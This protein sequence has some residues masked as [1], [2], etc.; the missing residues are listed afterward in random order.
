MK[1]EIGNVISITKSPNELWRELTQIFTIDNPKWLD[2]ERMGRWQGETRQWLKF[3]S[4][5][6][7]VILVPRGF[8]GLLLR[9]CRKMGIQYEVDDHR[10]VLPEVNFAFTGKLRSYQRQAVKDI[11]KR[12]FKVLQA[13]TGSGKTVMALSIIAKRRQPAL[14]IVHTKELLNQWLERIETF[15][16]IPKEQIGIIGNGKKK[17]GK[18]ITVGIIN[19]IYPIANE[20]KQYFGHVIVDECHR[21]P[22]KTFTNAVILFDSRYMLGLSATPY[23]QDGLTK[24]IG[25]FLGTQVSVDQSLLDSDD[26]IRNVEIVSRETKFVTRFNQSEEYPRMLRELTKDHDRNYMIVEDVAKEVKNPG[27]C[28]VLSDRKSH[29]KAL[30]NSLHD[31]G[32]EADVLTGDTNNHERKAIVER[33]NDGEIDVLIATAQLIGEGFDSKRLSTLFLTTPIKFDGRLI[34]YVGR[35]LRPAPG[36]DKAMVYDYV[37]V[38]VGVLKAAAKSRQRVYQEMNGG[39]NA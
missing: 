28:L 8:L 2:N 13:P 34:Q 29:C 9:L 11:G 18:E 22:S 19:S 36:K 17:V 15:L 7:D 26:I 5:E 16:E 33:L 3:Y 24:V 25:W 37:D 20:L 27:V 35:I 39:R 32:I 21:T 31:F 6:D 38:N 10:R 1:I 14:V 4:Y 23:R 12:R 30:R